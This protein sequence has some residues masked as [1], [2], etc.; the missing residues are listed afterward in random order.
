[1]TLSVW[2]TG[3]IEASVEAFSEFSHL[4]PVERAEASL[5]VSSVREG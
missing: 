5:G 3:T 2:L 1:M 4:D